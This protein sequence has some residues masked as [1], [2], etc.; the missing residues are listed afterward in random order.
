MLGPVVVVSTVALFA[1]GIALLVDPNG[2]G[3]HL[4][5]IHRASFFVWLAVTTI[6]V[7]GHLV[8]M[9][10]LAPRDWRPRTRRRIPG[11]GLRQVII[12]ASLAIGVLLAVVLVGRVTEF[13][14][15][16]HGHHRGFVS[17]IGPGATGSEPNPP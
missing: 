4:L 2:L 8:E 16:Y 5:L 6:H 3:G 11:A 14:Q 9:G 13:R 10:R 15:T 7:L 1:S 12:V 17:K